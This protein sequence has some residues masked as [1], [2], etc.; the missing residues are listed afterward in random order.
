MLDVEAAAALLVKSTVRSSLPGRPARPSQHFLG[1]ILDEFALD[2]TVLAR[3]HEARSL[4]SDGEIGALREIVRSSP[5][6]TAAAVML[7]LA[8]R[9]AGG[10][11]AEPAVA[12][13]TAAKIPRRVVQFWTDSRSHPTSPD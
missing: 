2:P 9:R 12:A 10:L 1:Q 11:R 4:P 5:E 13:G 3:L 6:S 7:L 8:L